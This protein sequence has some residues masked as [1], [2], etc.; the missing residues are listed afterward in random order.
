[1][2]LVKMGRLE[3]SNLYLRIEVGCRERR[4]TER[5]SQAAALDRPGC[6]RVQVSSNEAESSEVQPRSMGNN[7]KKKKTS[8]P[9]RGQIPKAWRDGLK[10]CWRPLAWRW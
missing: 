6:R 9:D 10:A 2:C 3:T 4:A 1:M 8:P 5:L 7:P